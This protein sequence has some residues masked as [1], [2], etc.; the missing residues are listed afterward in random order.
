MQTKQ[1]TLLGEYLVKE[2]SDDKR[3]T[4]IQQFQERHMDMPWKIDSSKQDH[5]GG[6][7]VMRHMEEYK[8]VATR[9]DVGLRKNEVSMLQAF[10][11]KSV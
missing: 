8:G 4:S 5:N 2:W 1:S 7:Y 6:I 9:W 10:S 11:F 3:G